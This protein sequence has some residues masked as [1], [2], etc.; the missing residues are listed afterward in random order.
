M[1]RLLGFLHL[2]LANLLAY[3][4]AL[5]F[6]VLLT[7]IAFV[8]ALFGGKRLLLFITRFWAYLLF[9]I[10]LRPVKVVGRELVDFSRP[11]LILMNHAS[12]FDIPLLY[13]IFPGKIQWISKETIFSIPLWGK[14]MR[15]LGCISMEREKLKSAKSSLEQ[16]VRADAQASIAMFPEGT[17]TP[18]G[19]LQRF[20]R[21]FVYILR[22]TE[23]DVL[24]IT[25]R[26]LFRFC[27]K[28]RFAVDPRCPI[29]VIFHKP[30]KR[31]ELVGKTDEEIVAY[32]RS[33]IETDLKESS[34]SH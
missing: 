12:M 32:V 6:T 3:L 5:P 1:R 20:K 30:L 7:P 8:I 13:R 22:N 16:A 19:E 9:M 25:F 21:G 33:V 23:Y 11:Y 17:R 2:V 18:T 26:G 14:I 4:F 27:P 10:T 24:P 29:E 28:H 15:E 34:C 31:E